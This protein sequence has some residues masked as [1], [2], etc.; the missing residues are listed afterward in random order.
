MWR[1]L[2]LQKM[3][4]HV[5]VNCSSEVQSGCHLHNSIHLRYERNELGNYT[6]HDPN[7][8]S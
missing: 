5:T 6:Y 1:E 7:N 4:C 3:V 2:I 8:K